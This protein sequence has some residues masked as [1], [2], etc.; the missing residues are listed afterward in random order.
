M[1]G[2]T[3]IQDGSKNP[4]GIRKAKDSSILFLLWSLVVQLNVSASALEDP[5]P[6]PALEGELLTRVDTQLPKDLASPWTWMVI[7]FTKGSA[8]DTEKCRKALTRDIPVQ[9]ADGRSLALL[10]GVP[11][12]LKGM[13]KGNLRS[14]IPESE[15][16]RFVVASEKKKEL[17]QV[18]HFDEKF[19]DQAYV[20]LVH[21]NQ[22]VWRARSSCD[23]T[24]YP[25]LLKS[26]K[27]HLP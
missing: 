8:K 21:Q 17:Q 4:G 25:E 13:I 2:A 22:V 26:L 24:S 1:S 15:W 11:F 6:F 16:S 19:E 5:V 3:G 18:T 7:G 27:S 23:E 14:S 12:F 20:I 9:Q 10:Q